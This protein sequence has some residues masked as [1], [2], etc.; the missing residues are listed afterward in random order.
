MALP[1]P[2]R[3]SICLITGASSGIGV[4]FAHGFARR[5]YGLGLV[6]RRTSPMEAL[7]AELRDRHHV[8]ADVFGCDLAVEAERTQLIE[9]VDAGGRAVDILVNN[10]GIG[11]LGRFEASAVEQQLRL[12][13]VNAEAPVHLC[14]HYVPQMVDRGRGAV[15]NLSSIAGFSPLPSMTTYAAA[16]AFVLSFTEAL[17]AELRHTGVTATVLAPGA[18]NTEFS[19]TA[20]GAHLAERFP[21]FVWTDTRQV[22]EQ[23]IDG[24]DRGKRL[25]VP[26]PLYKVAAQ[27]SRHA[28][29]GPL[30]RLAA[31]RR[32]T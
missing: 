4:E 31:L 24:L 9:K 8:D 11:W 7:A 18:V 12:V 14:A 6:A 22:A 19:P 10:A 29:R 28:P 13:R 25:V 32:P 5:G 15:L 23:G 21:G 16:K 3:G 1:P 17:H 30:V 2:G 26:G 27:L 20:G